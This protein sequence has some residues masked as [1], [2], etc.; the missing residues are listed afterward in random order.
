M[1]FL[2]DIKD[3]DFLNLRFLKK[4]K[5]FE[6]WN[7]Y[8]N[9]QL[10]SLLYLTE[11]GEKKIYFEIFFEKNFSLFLKGEIFKMDGF[12]IDFDS[13]RYST[14]DDFCS[15]FPSMKIISKL[16]FK[17]FEEAYETI[18]NTPFSKKLFEYGMGIGKKE[19]LDYL[20]Q[21]FFFDQFKR[22]GNTD[23]RPQRKEFFGIDSL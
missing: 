9:R 20:V 16:K 22:M 15:F 2:I 8:K 3:I 7:H 18:E 21:R 1:K 11:N 17:T 12:K 10:E 5:N 23:L 4:D 14:L 19:T 6:Y 13:E